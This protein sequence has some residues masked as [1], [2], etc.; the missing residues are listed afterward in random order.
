MRY[1]PEKTVEYLERNGYDAQ[2]DHNCYQA[3]KNY[4][5]DEG[6]KKNLKD[7][8]KHLLN[9]YMA[10]IGMVELRMEEM[11]QLSE[12][13]AMTQVYNPT[14]MQNIIDHEW[15]RGKRYHSPLSLIL[16]EVDGWDEIIAEHGRDIGNQTL[17]KLAE[18]IK[19]NIRTT[20]VLG[21]WYGEAFILVVPTTNNV[22]AQWLAQKLRKTID[23]T[24]FEGVGNLT[25][26]FGV[27]DRDAAMDV[28]DWVIILEMALKKAK[29]KGRN[30][31]IDYET[32]INEDE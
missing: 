3:L 9:D 14:K 18:I 29:E 23:G 12:T 20:D 7:F 26:S 22:Q 2:R 13:D 1:L 6:H 31:V 25:C 17:L 8:S 27:A 15:S 21:R 24:D 4:L 32:I 5:K 11:S 16:F 30:L 19:S 10:L 28:D